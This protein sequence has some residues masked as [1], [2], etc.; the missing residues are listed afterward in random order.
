MELM[1][2]PPEQVQHPINLPFNRPF[3][4]DVFIKMIVIK[5]KFHYISFY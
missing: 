4:N 1:E 2:M 3:L 5:E